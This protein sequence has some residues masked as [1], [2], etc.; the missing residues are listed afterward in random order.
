MSEP[1]VSIV[2]PAYKPDFLGPAIESALTQTWATTEIVVSD[3][4]PS[5]DVRELVERYPGIRYHP[6]P[7]RGVYANFRNCIRLARGEY[8]KFL[9]DDDLLAPSCVEQMLRGF[10]EHRD[11]TLV[12]ASYL[13]IDG[14]GRQQAV[15]RL[16]DRLLVSTPGGAAAPML[17]SARNPVGPLT[18]SMF[19]R[20]S[21]PLG[22]GPW[23]F[24]TAAPDRYLGL[25]DMAVILD[26]AFQGRVVMFPEPL[27][28]MRSHPGQL[29]NPAANPRLVHS[30]TSWH[31][32]VE[33]A[34]DFGLISA[35]Q[36]WQ[37]LQA[38]V[39]LYHRFDHLFPELE[40]KR[41][42]L[43]ALLRT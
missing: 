39:A 5:G 28:A 31:P 17:M 22:L 6:N 41:V 8:V 23:F 9:L 3:N 33:D 11:A 27:S 26:L 14:E 19:R 38:V 29:S 16:E 15:R 7:V 10:V 24:T 12:T 25:I 42:R 32:L 36:R 2:I 34:W 13:V 4:C 1:L 37:A 18:T 21:L 20:R 43:E 35:D 40:E 30:I